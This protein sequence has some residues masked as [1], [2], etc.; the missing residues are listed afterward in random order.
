MMVVRIGEWPVKT[1]TLESAHHYGDCPFAQERPFLGECPKSEN[2]A[3]E[4][5]PD[6]SLT[7]ENVLARFNGDAQAALAVAIEDIRYL[8]RELGYASVCMSIGFAR[9]W[10]P[11]IKG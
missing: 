3:G 1:A 10:R 2:W 5:V 4:A 9:G 8:E 11:G 7:L 6:D